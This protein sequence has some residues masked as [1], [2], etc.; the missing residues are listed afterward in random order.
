MLNTLR[1]G[2][3]IETVGLGREGLANAIQSVVGGTKT[4]DYRSWKIVDAKGRSWRVVPDGSLSGGEQSGEI[5]SPV[6]GYDDIDELQQVVRAVRN[7]GG[8]SDQ[9]CG[10]HY[11]LV[12]VMRERAWR[13]LNSTPLRNLARA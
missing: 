13:C 3:E 12:F 9:S 6:L 7:A 10:I 4:A 8:R 1:F 2:I 11:A 5:V